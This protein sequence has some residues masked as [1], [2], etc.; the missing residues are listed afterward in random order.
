[1][2]L[3]FRLRV[4]PSC[5]M[6]GR[7]GQ[8]LHCRPSQVDWVAELLELQC[9]LARRFRVEGCCVCAYQ[10]HGAPGLPEVLFPREVF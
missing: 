9:A 8:S 5:C 2:G 10:R 6:G 7:G 1:M 4:R 3:V